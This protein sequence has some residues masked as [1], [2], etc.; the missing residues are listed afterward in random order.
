MPG[1]VSCCWQIPGQR[2]PGRRRGSGLEERIGRVHAYHEHSDVEQPGLSSHS[3]SRSAPCRS[4]TVKRPLAGWGIPVTFAGWPVATPNAP[5]FLDLGVH[6]VADSNRPAQVA[7]AD[8]DCLP[9][10]PTVSD[11]GWRRDIIGAAGKTPPRFV[12]GGTCPKAERSVRL[13]SP[14]GEE[15]LALLLGSLTFRTGLR[16][17]RSAV[18]LSFRVTRGRTR[19]GG[20][21]S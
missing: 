16:R 4:A 2:S 21:A 3:I 10:A 5:T 9:P 17:Q 6:R 8:L 19:R 18:V 1:R 7:P 11:A 14:R 12:R 15:Q 20:E 13:S